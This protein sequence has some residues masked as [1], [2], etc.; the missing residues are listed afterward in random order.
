LPEAIGARSSLRPPASADNGADAGV[1]ALDLGYNSGSGNMLDAGKPDLGESLESQ[2][3]ID[4][5]WYAE[6]PEVWNYETFESDSPISMIKPG[7]GAYASLSSASKGIPAREGDER[8]PPAFNFDPGVSPL[9]IADLRVPNSSFVRMPTRNANL[10]RSK[11]SGGR[12]PAE[13]IE[14]EP[15]PVPSVPDLSGMIPPD[16]ATPRAEVRLPSS[17]RGVGMASDFA[18]GT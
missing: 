12:Q 5:P 16:A 17:S 9:L 4:G 13:I 3:G 8:I 2:A 1:E 14:K 11:S 7:E 15:A 6:E 18:P 10:F